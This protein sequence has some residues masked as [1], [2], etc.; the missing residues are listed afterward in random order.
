M[1]GS[2]RAKERTVAWPWLAGAIGLASIAPACTSH[3]AGPALSGSGG[4]SGSGGAPGGEPAASA[5]ASAGAAPAPVTSA[6]PPSCSQGG[7]LDGTYTVPVTPELEPYASFDVSSIQ[8]CDHGGS[9]SLSYDLPALLVGDSTHIAFSGVFDAKA[10]T[11]ELSGDRGSAS[12]SETGATWS[13]RETLTGIEIDA[14]KLRE[15]L[16]SRPAAEAQARTDVSDVFSQ[17]P[18]GVLTFSTP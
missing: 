11:L 5:G 7:N 18:I 16:A 9:T 13:C 2:S 17:D 10:P 1:G 15:R 3:D 6:P 8:F 12:C 14:D 4:S